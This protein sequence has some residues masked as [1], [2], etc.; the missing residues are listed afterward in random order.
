MDETKRSR[1]YIFLDK[2]QQDRQEIRIIASCQNREKCFTT[3]RPGDH[4]SL[5]GDFRLCREIW[6]VCSLYTFGKLIVL[7]LKVIFWGDFSSQ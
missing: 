5:P 4:K 2:I 7:Q 1:A 6:Q 3:G